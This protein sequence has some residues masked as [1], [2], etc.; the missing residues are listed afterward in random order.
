MT[1]TESINEHLSTLPAKKQS[2]VFDFVLFLEGKQEEAKDNI[3]EDI[4][5]RRRQVTAALDTL[6]Q[7]TAFAHVADPVAWQREIRRD[8]P[9]PGREDAE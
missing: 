4:E 9:L 8:R 3:G 7:S 6:R 5:A 1:L 2:E